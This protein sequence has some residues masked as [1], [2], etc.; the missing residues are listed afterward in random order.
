ML[1]KIKFIIPFFLIFLTCGCGVDSVK[2]NNPLTEKEII[3]YIQN[4]IYKETGDETE[5]IIKNKKELSV[6][7]AW[8]D[9][10]I[11]YQTVENGYSYEVE[12]VNKGNDIVGT[13]TYDDGYIL[14]DKQYTDGKDERDHYFRNNYKEQKGLFLIKNEFINALNEKFYKY[15][16]Y[17]D[18]SNDKG[19]DI[20]INSSN[21]DDIKDLL[22]KFKDTVVKYRSLA[23]TSY[24]VYIYKDE[25]VFNNTNFDL[26]KNGSE[27]YRGQS[28]GESMIK[29]YT[30]KEATR[31]GVSKGF[32]YELFTSNGA[33]AA[34]TN[35]EYI[36]YN[37][38][39]Y[40]VFWYTAEPNAF[41]GSN[42]SSMQI[43]GVK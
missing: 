10:C 12:I 23:Y 32:D 27:N 33:S 15:Y 9:G 38:F 22:L 42:T 14:Y 29:Q 35:K 3:D 18:V 34:N 31:I 6:C 40:L 28:Y 30:G 25:D 16:I 19:Y 36:D 1:K 17:K 11:S 5:I 7:T 4:E 21:Y 37:T 20:F 26:Y 39:E 41:V 43:F 2:V 13:G 8:F 24:S